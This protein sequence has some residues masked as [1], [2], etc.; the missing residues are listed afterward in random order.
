MKNE[1]IAY[2]SYAL[3]HYIPRRKEKKNRNHEKKERK[4]KKNIMLSVFSLPSV[5]CLLSPEKKEK[6]HPVSACARART[7]TRH[8]CCTLLRALHF[9][10]AHAAHR[11]R[12]LF[13]AIKCLLPRTA[14]RAF[15]RCTLRARARCRLCT[16]CARAARMP[17]ARIKSGRTEAW[18]EEHARALRAHF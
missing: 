2:I 6:H 11:A 17:R 13:T 1:N 18:M 5:I 4:E 16:A 14:A 9:C 8:A 7:H 15:A 12:A 3:L 10:C